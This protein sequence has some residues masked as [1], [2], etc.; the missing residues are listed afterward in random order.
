MKIM[1]GGAPS[2]PAVYSGA[3]RDLCSSLLCTDDQC[4]ATAADVADSPLVRSVQ[5]EP[6]IVDEFSP[7]VPTSSDEAFRRLAVARPLVHAFS[8]AEYERFM[9]QQLEARDS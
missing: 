3:L 8:P 9:V 1:Q 5:K 2:L 7:V 6:D 4:R